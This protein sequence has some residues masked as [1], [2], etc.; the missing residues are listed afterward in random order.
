ME[1]I[2]DKVAIIGMGCSQFGENWD[3]SADD[4]IIDAVYE[5]YDD[6]GLGREDIQAVWVGTAFSGI[7][8]I[9]VSGPLKLDR[10]PITRVENF[11][12]TGMETIRNATYAIAAGVYDV[13]LCIGFEKLKDSGLAGLPA[14]YTHP[15]LGVN[16]T[17]PGRWAMA[18]TRY[19]QTYGIDPQEGKKTLAR[20]SVKSHYN[21]AR[22]PKA[23]LR[24]E[25]TI[26]QVLSAPI[27][28]WPL[29]LFDCCG[30]TDGA[31]A[32]IL[33]RADMAK[34]FRDDYVLIKGIGLAIGP[35]LGKED[36]SYDYIHLPETEAAAKQAY[37][38]AG[39]TNP[40]K[41][42]D[43]LEL[44]DCFTISELLTL[45][46]IGICP[47]GKAKEDIDAGTFT[48]TG[49]LPVN[50][51]GGLKSFG[52]PIGA[53][54]LRECYEVYKQIQGKAELAERQLKDVKLGLSHNQGG[55]PGSLLPIITILGQA[56]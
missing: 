26:E 43:I 28:A 25:V 15:V 46:A 45:E 32:A 29:G 53:S 19:F 5:A 27:I 37:E 8:G 51:D 23:H 21:G 4:M 33:T 40:R 48:L 47:K 7:G 13:V 9:C 3:K 17:A 11:C 31:A 56:G 55:H 36:A 20:I 49:E 22:H 24:K 1:T 10:I 6:A 18:A 35:G 50:A 16:V 52:H 39:I 54:G 41:E 38:Q 2:K 44:H 14:G 30:N 42:L 34:S 12:A